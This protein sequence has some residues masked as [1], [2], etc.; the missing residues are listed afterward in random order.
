MFG[1]LIS[2]YR[3]KNSISSSMY[4]PFLLLVMVLSMKTL[5]RD[6]VQ[7]FKSL[8]HVAFMDFKLQ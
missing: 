5:L 3:Q 6:S 2:S 8:K 4:L 7:K 1:K